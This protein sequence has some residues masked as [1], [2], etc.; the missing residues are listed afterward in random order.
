LLLVMTADLSGI[1]PVIKYGTSNLRAA[2]AAR[3][4]ARAP[5]HLMPSAARLAEGL[6]AE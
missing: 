6:T 2:V 4:R 1:S 3:N 5:R